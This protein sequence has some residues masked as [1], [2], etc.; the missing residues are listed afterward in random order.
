MYEYSLIETIC[1]KLNI[2]SNIKNITIVDEAIFSINTDKINKILEDYK[3]NNPTPIE[4]YIID[5][6][7]NKCSNKMNI[8]SSNYFNNSLL[9][10]YLILGNPKL[11]DTNHLTSLYYNYKIFKLIID[12]IKKDYEK[13]LSDPILYKFYNIDIINK[14][15]KTIIQ[16]KLSKDDYFKISTA[17][18]TFKKSR[19]EKYE[20]LWKKYNESCL[21]LKEYLDTV[22]NFYKYK[23]I[24]TVG[25]Y[26]IE[27]NMYKYCLENNLGFQVDIIKLKAWAERELDILIDTMKKT[28]KLID[29]KIDTSKKHVEIIKEIGESQKYKSKEEFVEHHQQ[30]IKKYENIYITKFGFKDYS[31]V[32]LVIFDNKY[33]AGGYYFNESFYLNAVNWNESNKYTVESLVLHEALPGHYLQLHPIKYT[34]QENNLL[35]SYFT[36]IING[37]AEGWGLFSEK[38]GV[39]QTLWDKVGQLEY[40][41][42]RTLRIIIDVSI[43]YEGA[44]PKVMF[45]Y[46][47]QYLAFSENEINSEIYRYVCQPGQ[48]VSY[49]VG[50]HIFETIIK[51]KGIKNLM[52]PVALEIYKKI[53]A[54][55]HMPL[56]FLLEKYNI[57][58]SDLFI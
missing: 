4:K 14:W 38:L 45:D 39:D 3:T 16:K 35:L 40:E 10:I 53:I 20:F 42:F 37:F 41:I 49:K 11:I 33:L 46:M 29:P 19:W 51:N 27:K 34:N 17:N 21:E 8:L 32:S 6:N 28:L 50:S 44:T 43:H 47:K 55:G 48:A 22:E 12:D 2:E 13:I 57:N 25:C 52:D 1:N 31:R 5:V 30:I 15:Q 58:Q 56:K 54:D 36:S 26:N 23:K 7:L 24:E 9:N 18:T